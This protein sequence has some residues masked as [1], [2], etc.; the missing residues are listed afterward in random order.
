MPSDIQATLQRVQARHK[1]VR[2]QLSSTDAS[3]VLVGTARCVASRGRACTLDLQTLIDF[4]LSKEP[5]GNTNLFQGSVC[6]DRMC[7][8]SILAAQ[9]WFTAV[10]KTCKAIF[11]TPKNQL[12]D[13]AVLPVSVSLT[14][15]APSLKCDS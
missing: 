4:G 5:F 9:A 3:P 10:F 1:K 2:E 15:F 12:S 6:S 8:G 14:D 11:A 13:T 7:V